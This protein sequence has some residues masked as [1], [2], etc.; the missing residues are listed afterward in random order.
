MLS[1]QIIT[2]RAAFTNGLVGAVAMVLFFIVAKFAVGSGIL[3]PME[4]FTD[5]VAPRLPMT[6]FESSISTFGGFAK[7]LLDI[8]VT[9][10]IL[11]LGGLIGLA[12]HRFQRGGPA[13]STTSD[14]LILTS[15]LS[16]FGLLIF[17]PIT[18]RGFFGSSTDIGPLWASL[19]YIAGFA[20]YSVVLVTGY[21]LSQS[22]GTQY[23][24]GRR[25]LLRTVFYGGGAAVAVIAV[26]SVFGQIKSSATVTNIKKKASGLP[27]RFTPN[28]KFYKVSKNLVDPRVNPGSWKLTVA[29][30][31]RKQLSLTLPELKSMPS[32]HQDQTLECISNPVGG[33]LISNA[34]WKG[35]RL[36]NLLNEAGVQDGAVDIKLTA[37]D[38]YTDSI[39]LKK[40]MER[41]VILAY[42]MNGEP[43]P[44]EHGGPVRLLVPNIYGMKNVK[45]ITRI[46]P[47]AQDFKGY[48]ET[49]GWSDTAVIKTMS[50]IRA[51]HD[52][53]TLKVNEQVDVS[54]IAFA[55]SRRIR[56]VEWSPDY[57]QTWQEA[58]LLE[59]IGP[60]CW[61]FWK[62]SWTPTGKGTASLLVRATD[63]TGT[64]QTASSVPTLPD[65]ASG[66]DGVTV[67]VE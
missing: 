43:V 52:G 7:V 50:Q 6:A 29:G 30:G 14:T 18:G 26:G 62:A 3:T 48:W 65:G 41:N 56:K 12:Y 16:V 25:R 8:G 2:K 53:T 21:N 37:T 33:N 58:Q 1:P 11:G 44:A 27:A 4:T 64:L 15:L 47:V 22:T 32:I 39:P 17:L 13:Y 54:G 57:G 34:R 38:G 28:S 36:S 66:Y 63:G 67:S 60:L 49:Q 31:V 42:E 59:E 35:V 46:E 45:W 19:Y 5:W 51:P 40:G 55:G 10:G 23:N 9:V 24:A 20:L 61:R